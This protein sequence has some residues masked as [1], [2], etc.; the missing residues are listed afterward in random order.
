MIR[1]EIKQYNMILT[2]NLPKISSLQSA[3]VDQSEYQNIIFFIL[4]AKFT[5]YPLGKAFKNKHKERLVL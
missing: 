4:H 3:K 5:H 1:L 2:E